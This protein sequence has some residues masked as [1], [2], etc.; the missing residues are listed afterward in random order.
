MLE[1][2]MDKLL[3]KYTAHVEPVKV[4]KV[5]TENGNCRNCIFNQRT[6]EVE[7]MFGYKCNKRNLTAQGWKLDELFIAVNFDSWRCD[8]DTRF[9][10]KPGKLK[11]KREKKQPKRPAVKK[12]DGITPLQAALRARNEEIKALHAAG[13]SVK[14]ITLIMSLHRC[15]VHR[16][17]KN[18][19]KNQL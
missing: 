10:Y 13:I 12:A 9:S 17:L 6:H 7:R 18:K 15:T 8:T 14:D 2:T 3:A 5:T 19:Q 4:W 1:G 16:I 11:F